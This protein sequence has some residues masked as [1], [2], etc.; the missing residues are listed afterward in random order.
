M[1]PGRIVRGA[2]IFAAALGIFGIA[3]AEPPRVVASIAPI[4][5]LIA[6]VM[7]GIAE[8]GLIIRGYGSPHDYRL[9][10]SEARALA[11]AELVFRVG[12]SLD[13]FLDRP[14]AT[15]ARDARVVEVLA[16]DGL[17]LLGAR[18]GGLW[19]DKPAAAPAPY[20]DQTDPHVWLDPGNAGRIVAEAMRRLSEA[21]PANAPLYAANAAAVLGRIDATDRALGRRLAGVGDIPY[22]VAHD[23]F[24]YFERR[25]GLRA[26]GSISATPERLPGARRLRELRSAIATQGV[27]CMF[28]APGFEP[29]PLGA[30][31]EGSDVGRGVLD[32]LGARFAPGP[33]AYF[34]MLEAN[35]A[36]LVSCLTGRR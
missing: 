5:S 23:A 12:R 27:R 29:A 28:H 6:G 2:L 32:P 9:R 34:Q 18:A 30:I 21:D 14:L 7:R 1:P 35:A 20:P 26:L 16:L 36:A 8:P 31:L 4:H 11:E 17:A 33:D 22:L 3:A 25:Y 24:Q 15:L 13:G 10:P 19:R